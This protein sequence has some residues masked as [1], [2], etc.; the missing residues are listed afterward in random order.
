MFIALWF[1]KFYSFRI[2]RTLSIITGISWAILQSIA[3]F[4]TTFDIGYAK[5][6]SSIAD[7]TEIITM[8]IFVINEMFYG[9]INKAS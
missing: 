2:G 8:L 9:N 6:I 3:V 5:E 4:L 7:I 1:K